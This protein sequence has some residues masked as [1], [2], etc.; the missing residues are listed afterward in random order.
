MNTVNC[1]VAVAVA[2]AVVVVVVVVVGLV[3]TAEMCKVG[4]SLMLFERELLPWIHD[5]CCYKVVTSGILVDQ[6]SQGQE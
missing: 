4:L 5:S 2:A 6:C 1:T 3:L